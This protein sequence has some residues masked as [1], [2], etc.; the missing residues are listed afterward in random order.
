MHAPHKPV[1]TLCVCGY[2]AVLWDDTPIFL[3][4]LCRTCFGVVDLRAVNCAS[5][6]ILSVLSVSCSRALAHDV[7][8]AAIW[9]T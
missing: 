4:C 1:K 7:R 9:G 8:A 3:A 5:I 2:V 6:L